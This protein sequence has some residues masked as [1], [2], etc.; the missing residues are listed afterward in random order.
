MAIV[1]ARIT[2]TD[3]KVQY[4]VKKKNGELEAWIGKAGTPYEDVVHIKSI[5]YR[6]EIVD[7]NIVKKEIEKIKELL[8]ISSKVL[9]KFLLKGFSS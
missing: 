9:R 1:K 7:N 5:I 6:P 2:D 3:F 8:K 4:Q